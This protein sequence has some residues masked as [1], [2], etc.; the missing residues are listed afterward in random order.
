[1]EKDIK[2]ILI[3]EQELREKIKEMGKKISE[4]YKNQEGEL[5]VVGILKGASVFMSDLIR[6]ISLPIT[7][8]FM[9]VSS[10]GKDRAE[11]T[12]V[13]RILKDLD[14]DIEG[15]HLIIVEDIVDS[16]LTLSYL[17][18][19][20]IR[21]GARSVKIATL[22]DKPSGRKNHVKIDY[23]GFEVPEEFI[24]GYGIDYSEKY[25]NLP[26]IASLKKELYDK[27]STC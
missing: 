22:L 10:Y 6:Q 18:D 2:E 16:G 27:S 19:M 21:R 14:Y 17:S 3:N 11:S 5:L 20:F 15:K 8:D 13:V 12:G 24:V 4:D 25:R 7:I 1:M 9:A 26:Y 23:L